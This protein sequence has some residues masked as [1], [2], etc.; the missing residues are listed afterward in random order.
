MKID[1]EGW[2]VCLLRVNDVRSLHLE[3][4]AVP[5]NDDPGHCEIRPTEQQKFTDA[6]WSKLA[7]KTRMLTEREIARLQPGDDIHA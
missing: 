1:P 2:G 6:I 3:V 5:Q 4:V 7:K